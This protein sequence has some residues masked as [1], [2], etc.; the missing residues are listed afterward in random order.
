MRYST[1]Q[2]AADAK[3]PGGWTGFSYVPVIYVYVYVCIY[4]YTWRSRRV[5]NPRIVP[6]EREKNLRESEREVLCAAAPGT[7]RAAG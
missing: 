1:K 6:P 2:R 4:T 7:P 5:R 3:M